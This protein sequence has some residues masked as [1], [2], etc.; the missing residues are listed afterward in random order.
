M[1]SSRNVLEI[2]GRV[3]IALR[4]YTKVRSTSSAM[5]HR[6][7]IERNVLQRGIGTTF[8]QLRVHRVENVPQRVDAGARTTGGAEESKQE[9]AHHP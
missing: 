3:Y 6:D 4:M 5:L 2:T 8:N 1:D 7:M 9:P